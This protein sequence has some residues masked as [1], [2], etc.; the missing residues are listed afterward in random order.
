MARY[1]EPSCKKCR[2]L[3]TKLFLKG[4]RCLGDKCPFQR[5]S[6]IPGQH[7]P[8]ARRGKL[9]DYGAHLTEKQ[10]AKFYY[11]LMENQFRKYFE[12]ASRQR[13][14]PTG[15]RLIQLLE[16]RL[17]NVLY[18]SGIGVSRQMARQFVL[19]KKILVNGRCVNIP[20][21]RLRTGDKITLK[22]NLKKN[23]YAL[24]FKERNIT[25]PPWIN[26]D[27]DKFEIEILREPLR[28]EISVPFNEQL[29]VEFYSK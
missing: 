16:R 2:R 12:E 27:K 7:G 26:I 17:D 22:E 21:Y 5:R 4:D 15:D 13:K 6:Y 14:I 8:V 25:P 11:G 1:I 19:H 3:N 9:T 24:A 20:S 10:R 23:V 18:R 29:I 28:E